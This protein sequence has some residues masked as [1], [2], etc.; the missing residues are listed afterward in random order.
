MMR[1]IRGGAKKDMNENI[2]RVMGI[3][4]AG[5]KV[6]SADKWE[7]RRCYKGEK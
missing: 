6:T 1:Y 4:I 3:G 2:V 7:R 5:P